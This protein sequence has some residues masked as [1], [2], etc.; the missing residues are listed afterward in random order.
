[1]PALPANARP[2]VEDS[3]NGIAVNPGRLTLGGEPGKPRAGNP[4][5]GAIAYLGTVHGPMI[6][7]IPK[8]WRV[9]RSI[10]RSFCPRPARVWGR[11]RPRP[12]HPMPPIISAAAPDTAG[13]VIPRTPP[14][15]RFTPAPA[16]DSGFTPPQG[17]TPAQDSSAQDSPAQ[18]SSTQ[19]S[20]PGLR[21]VAPFGGWEGAPS[22]APRGRVGEGGPGATHSEIRTCRGNCCVVLEPGRPLRIQPKLRT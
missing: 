14:R 17:F 4:G 20:H 9:H 21:D 3:L 15:P 10:F 7:Q 16:Q 11:P 22:P 1:M 12:P 13:P 19:G 8:V 2:T 6:R 5:Q 18:G